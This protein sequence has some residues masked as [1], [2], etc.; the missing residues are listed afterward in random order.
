MNLRIFFPIN[1]CA[2]YLVLLRLTNLCFLAG[3][4]FADVKEVDAVVEGKRDDVLVELLVIAGKSLEATQ[5]N[6]RHM[7]QYWVQRLTATSSED[8]LLLL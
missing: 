1:L 6:V 7:N 3:E 2:F 5:G 4:G 8:I